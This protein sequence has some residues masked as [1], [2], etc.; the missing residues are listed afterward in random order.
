MPRVF[1]CTL[2]QGDLGPSVRI[3]VTNDSDGNAPS[4]VGATITFKLLSVDATTGELVEVFEKAA[5][6][7]LPSATSGVLRYDW[8]LGDTDVLGLFRGLFKVVFDGGVP[9]HYP[10]HGYIWID[11]ESAGP[12]P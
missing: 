7:E 12:S 4:F 9:E 6:V 1:R 5:L 10:T 8:A 2:K 11:V 3:H